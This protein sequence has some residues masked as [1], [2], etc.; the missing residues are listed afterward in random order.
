MRTR[1]PIRVKNKYQKIRRSAMRKRHFNRGNI[2]EYFHKKNNTNNWQ[3]KVVFLFLIFII[4]YL[5]CVY[6]V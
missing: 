4:V 2:N 5:I 3:N 1:S 6:P